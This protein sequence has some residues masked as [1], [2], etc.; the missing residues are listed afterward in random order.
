MEGIH[1]RLLIFEQ[2]VVGPAGEQI[3]E[4]HVVVQAFKGPELVGEPRLGAQG[5]IP[6]PVVL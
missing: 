3:H 4:A 5:L 6:E 1:S 2:L